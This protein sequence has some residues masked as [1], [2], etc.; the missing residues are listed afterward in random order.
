MIAA[1]ILNPIHNRLSYLLIMNF[2]RLKKITE[3]DYC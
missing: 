2:E 3:N 1:V